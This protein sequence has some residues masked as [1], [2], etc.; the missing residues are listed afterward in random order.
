MSPSKLKW[1]LG[2][3]QARDPDGGRCCF[4]KRRP[5]ERHVG[6]TIRFHNWLNETLSNRPEWIHAFT[7]CLTAVDFLCNSH[8]TCPNEHGRPRDFKSIFLLPFFPFPLPRI[9]TIPY[10]LPRSSPFFLPCR[11][12]TPPTLPAAKRLPRWRW[13]SRFSREICW[14][15]I[16]P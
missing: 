4:T 7:E 15:R 8:V 12:A 10:T 1:S 9:G 11:V 16:C 6:H 2:L 3:H 5:A 14:D 13:G